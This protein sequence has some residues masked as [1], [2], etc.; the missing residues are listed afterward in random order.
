MA[1]TKKF[2]HDAMS[3]QN[4]H[5]DREHDSPQNTAIDPTRTHLN[6]SFPMAYHGMKPFEYYKQ[7]VEE[8]YLY[9]RGSK[10]E[11][12]Q[13]Q[14]LDGLSHFQKNYLDIQKKKKHFFMDAINSYLKG[15]ERKISSIIR[16]IMMKVAYHI[17]M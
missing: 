8:V 9:G 2:T 16:F 3:D 14:E 11:K 1:S 4:R 10:R 13:L 6:Y 12:K 7:R 15:M 17:F 5:V